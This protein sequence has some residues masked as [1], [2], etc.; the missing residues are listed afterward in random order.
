MEG[1]PGPKEFIHKT[2]KLDSECS[3]NV[4]KD[5]IPTMTNEMNSAAHVKSVT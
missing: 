5:N 3:E 2:E 4:L 1:G